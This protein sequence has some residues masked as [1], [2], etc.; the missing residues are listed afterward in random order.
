MY[1]E[2]NEI[3][4]QIKLKSITTTDIIQ[5]EKKFFRKIESSRVLEKIYK[6]RGKMRSTK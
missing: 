1:T 6:E 4:K 5:T 3:C 2:A